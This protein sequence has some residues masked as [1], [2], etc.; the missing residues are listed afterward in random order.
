MSEISYSSSEELRR[1]ASQRGL[2]L[3][4][5]EAISNPEVPLQNEQNADIPSEIPAEFKGE[6]LAEMDKRYGHLGYVMPFEDYQIYKEFLNKKKVSMWN[7]IGE[8]V[9]AT[10]TDLT[11]GAWELT[12]DVATLKVPKVVGS[13]IE[14]AAVGTK[15]WLYMYEQAKYD[16]NSWLSKM[17]FDNHATPEDEYLSY[18][19]A[20]KVREMIHKDQNEGIWVPPKV[21]VGGMEIDLTNPAV[22]QAISYVADPSWLF[23]NLGVESA[24]AK[25]MRGAT[26]AVGLGENLTKASAYALKKASQGFGK[27][28]DM[29]ETISAKI[30]KVD[31]GVGEVMSDMT[32]H[33]HHITAQG[34]IQGNEGLVRS[35]ES[36]LGVNKVTIPAWAQVTMVWGGAKLTEGIGRLGET[37]FKLAS[38]ESKIAGMALSERVALE[39]TNKSIQKVATFWSQNATPFVEWAT[40]TTKVGL[41][42]SMYGGAFGFA[43]GGEEGLYHGLGTGFV[44]GSAFNQ[45]GVL[46]NTVSGGDA[47]RDTVK[48]FLWATSHYDFHNQEGVMRY[49]ENAYAEGGTKAQLRVMSQ[50]AAAER[51]LP[52]DPIRILTEKKIKEMSN[53]I[54][55]EAYERQNLAN[56]EFGGITFVKDKDGKSVILIN[57]D[58]AARSAVSEETFHGLL[59]TKRYGKE[60]SKHAID[61]LVGTEDKLGALYRMPKDKAVALLEQFRDQYFNLEKSTTGHIPENMSGMYKKFNDAIER[62]KGGEKP[63]VLNGFFEEFMASYWNRFVEEKPLDYL[64]KGGDLGLIRNAIEGAKDFYRNTMAKDLQEAGVQLVKGETADMFLIDQNTKQRVRIPMLEKLMKHYVKELNSGMYDGWA[65]NNKKYADTNTLLNSDFDHLLRQDVESGTMSPKSLAEVE[66]EMQ[67]RIAALAE[68]LINLPKE[69][70]GLKLDLMNESGESVAQFQPAKPRKK[71]PKQEVLPETTKPSDAIDLQKERAWFD[72]HRRRFSGTDVAPADL[73]ELGPK[74]GGKPRKVEREAGTGRWS[75]EKEGDFWESVWQ[76]NPRVRITG[77]ATPKE[78]SLFEQYLGQHTAARLR[79]LNLVIET[80]RAGRTDQISNIIRSTVITYE[81]STEDGREQGRFV[82]ERRFVPLELN[83]YFKA[84]PKGKPKDG[85]QKYVVGEA[86]LLTTV[87]DWDA[88][89]RR[90]DFIYNKIDDGELHFKGVRNLFATQQN[91]RESVKALLSNYSLGNQ[92]EAGLK[93]FSRGRGGERDAALK[94]DIVNAAIGFHPTKEMMKKR[95]YKNA[96]LDFQMRE[97]MPETFNVVK[98]FRVDRMSGV[99]AENGEGFRYD[100]NEAYKRVQANFSPAITRRDNNGNIIPAGAGHIIKDTVYRNKEG[101]H[102]AVYGLRTPSSEILVRADRSRVFDYVDEGLADSMEASIPSLRGSQYTSKNGWLH[103]TPDIYEAGFFEDKQMRVGYIDSQSHLDISDIPFGTDMRTAVSTVASRIAETTG[104]PIGKVTEDLL[105]MKDDNGRRIFDTFQK[106]TDPI[107]S[108]MPT[109]DEWLMTANSK[110]L[111]RD[112]GI[113]SVGYKNTNPITGH[114]YSS[115]A[116]FEPKRF[117]E[118]RQVKG[119]NDFMFQPSKTIGDKYKEMVKKAGSDDITA[120]LKFKINEAGEVVPRDKFEH[121]I[122]EQSIRDVVNFNEMLVSDALK[123]LKDEKVFTQETY[124]RFKETMTPKVAQVLRERFKSAPKEVIDKIAQFSMDGYATYVS[125]LAVANRQISPFGRETYIPKVSLNADSALIQNASKYGIT[126]KTLAETGIPSLGHWVEMS[127][128]EYMALKNYKN[129]GRTLELVKNDRALEAGAKIAELEKKGTGYGRRLSKAERDAIR[130]PLLDIESMRT[131]AVERILR[132]NNGIAGLVDNMAERQKQLV[133]LVDASILGTGKIGDDNL[134][135]STYAK[136]RMMEAFMK[137]NIGFARQLIKTERGYARQSMQEIVTAYDAIVTSRRDI[138]GEASEAWAMWDRQNREVQNIIS[139][140]AKQRILDFLSAYHIKDVNPEILDKIRAK[141]YDESA[142]GFIELGTPEAIARSVE[143]YAFYEANGKSNLAR[144]RESIKRNYIDSINALEKEGFYGVRWQ[145]KDLS[146]S[147]GNVAINDTVT[148][149][150]VNRAWNFDGTHLTVIEAISDK[151]PSERILTLHDK[152]GK[153]LL[154][155]PFQSRVEKP[156]K[157]NKGTTLVEIPQS[158]IDDKVDLFLQ[159]STQIVRNKIGTGDIP[160]QQL[161]EGPYQEIKGNMKNLLLEIAKTKRG[162][163][164]QS[165]NDRYRLYRNGD[166]F[167]AQEINNEL[168]FDV[169]SRIKQLEEQLASGKANASRRITDAERINITNR[170]NKIEEILSQ[171][172]FGNP[173]REQELRIEMGRLNEQLESGTKK[174]DKLS[175]T[176]ELGIDEKVKLRDEITRL[177]KF[178]TQDLGFSFVID[179]KYNAEVVTFKFGSLTERN[180]ELTKMV[181][182]K[183]RSSNAAFEKFAEK[184]FLEFNQFLNGQRLKEMNRLGVILGEG[185]HKDSV[186]PQI[187]QLMGKL[188]EM[189]KVQ[190]GFYNTEK[191]RINN[192]RRLNGQKPL[193]EKKIVEQIKKDLDALDDASIEA[194]AMHLAAAEQLFQLNV[195]DKMNGMTPERVEELLYRISAKR[196]EVDL[197]QYHMPVPKNKDVVGMIGELQRSLVENGNKFAVLQ[198][199]FNQMHDGLYGKSDEQTAIKEQIG[200]LSRRYLYAKGIKLNAKR[201]FIE[202]ATLHDFDVVSK[203]DYMKLR[204][205]RPQGDGVSYGEPS[206]LVDVDGVLGKGHEEYRTTKDYTD[207]FKARLVELKSYYDIG[208]T[209]GDLSIKNILGIELTPAN[210]DISIHHHLR[211]RLTQKNLGDEGYAWA[212]DPRNRKFIKSLDTDIMEGR[213]D[214][215][216]AVQR[217]KDEQI[218]S[219]IGKDGVDLKDTVQAMSDTIEKIAIVANRLNLAHRGIELVDM[220]S[221][222]QSEFPMFR[223]YRAEIPK[224]IPKLETEL[225]KLRSLKTSLKQRYENILKKA[226]DDKAPPEFKRLVAEY[227]HIDYRE[228]IAKKNTKQDRQ[229][230]REMEKLRKSSIKNLFRQYDDFAKNLG[231]KGIK[232]SRMEIHPSDPRTQYIAYAFPEISSD[233]FQSSWRQWDLNTSSPEGHPNAGIVGGRDSLPEAGALPN[234]NPAIKAWT[235]TVGPEVRRFI[236][237]ES[238]DLK[239]PV[240]LADYIHFAHAKRAYHERNPSMPMSAAD[241]HLLQFFFPR[242]TS[243]GLL[244]DKISRVPEEKMK[245]HEAYTNGILDNLKSSTEKERFIRSFVVDALDLITD[246]GGLREAALKKLKQMSDAEFKQW[247]EQNPDSVDRSLNTIE[248]LEQSMYLLKNGVV[249][250]GNKGDRFNYR[251]SIHTT[252]SKDDIARIYDIAKKKKWSDAEVQKYID[253]GI[254]DVTPKE[255]R[256]I[257]ARRKSPFI[258][259]SDIGHIP[260]DSLVRMQGFMDVWKQEVAKHTEESLYGIERNFGIKQM[261]EN[262]PPQ[263]RFNLDMPTITQMMKDNERSN[264]IAARETKKRYKAQNKE[265]LDEASLEQFQF[266]E[267]DTLVMDEWS[268]VNQILSQALSTEASFIKNK[269]NAQG[270]ISSRPFALDN[271]LSMKDNLRVTDLRRNKDNTMSI[272]W[273]NPNKPN[274]RDTIDGRYFIK[275]ELTK[276]K[277]GS[278][279]ERF[280]IYFKGERFATPT[281]QKVHEIPTTRF[282]STADLTEAQVMIRFFED[283]VIRVK[284]AAAMI[285]GGNNKFSE[286]KVGEQDYTPL[287]PKQGLLINWGNASHFAEEVLKLYKE[288]KGKP[289]FSQLMADKL[290]GIGQYGEMHYLKWDVNGKPRKEQLLITP[291]KEGVMAKYFDRKISPDGHTLWVRKK[292]DKPTPEPNAATDE[293]PAAQGNATI[294]EEARPLS[295]E[296]KTVSDVSN[297]EIIQSAGPTPDRPFEDWVIVRNRLKYTII[298]IDKDGKSI[299]RVFNPASVFMA[300]TYHEYEAVEEM[301]KQ[302]MK[303]YE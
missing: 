134:V 81:K 297:F 37:T 208:L 124:K 128:G 299:F 275:R 4:T 276:D 225:K 83:M 182:H 210:T 23:P 237:Q 167:I 149:K 76:G 33:E 174:S 110:K 175:K 97:A 101:E 139:D 2:R 215:N 148:I 84:K 281:G 230:L 59:L 201:Q 146:K 246:N 263:E 21:N 269:K 1:Y 160:A 162:F 11:T 111:F 194:E 140:D 102:I 16:K 43:F 192:E 129:W 65:L 126:P 188:N 234:A 130:V 214:H 49:L 286:F 288:N 78:I 114:E 244:A 198:D 158:I 292:S 26:A 197:N 222:I 144:I 121:Q 62:F 58:R 153:V 50:I 150:N 27:L 98:S 249:T 138:A 185:T 271:L 20:L 100:H 161:I 223:K 88:Y 51:L 216:E 64:L 298:K 44:I 145:S 53:S 218:I 47:V 238:R 103:F 132:E 48:Q 219:S 166:Y 177:K 253:A 55:W 233:F 157:D 93:L 109:M 200:F 36:G 152:D 13:S 229:R 259:R 82:E 220:N 178:Q 141:L 179:K 232:D 35:A 169:P 99:R 70:R 250:V 57:A 133:F 270:F 151:N 107:S 137:R 96:P 31:K 5:E 268:R 112:Y 191:K 38:E 245:Q 61:A 89:L 291:M 125:S 251:D 6:Y 104:T 115:V 282:A 18:Q 254:S 247:K 77:L 168:G 266:G 7:S 184:A 95:R 186:I 117:I 203:F 187:R 72:K 45:I 202:Q 293:N 71:K 264:I 46:H 24:I 260:V 68:A 131:E 212:N 213:I 189:E 32:G 285:D 302:E 199:K 204:T 12:K 248:V 122:T 227:R 56:P 183:G 75:L 15:N 156:T 206:Y 40:N 239:R 294:S 127:E 217:I 10:T 272:D 228:A 267:N 256:P 240:Y 277:K 163:M 8:A 54:E 243:R 226:G 92:A 22:V 105:R 119:L 278:P 118:N 73:S 94:R 74:K 193:E 19:E 136:N 289:F 87:F 209:Q 211:N 242:E 17:L 147:N 180:T 296:E 205:M 221:D 303:Q 181:L 261:Y 29:G 287:D 14:G 255:L 63:T 60:F 301:L 120:L 42:S 172:K 196:R 171:S 123:Y 113:N 290:E 135:L 116:V 170:V 91:L 9:A 265:I 79:E 108:S 300:E 235:S 241:A 159:E 52:D 224:D 80:S 85:I 67:G 90:E 142:K 190:R 39:S 284:R 25:G 69:D 165:S 274:F 34:K 231:M 257:L 207:E 262:L 273:D 154:R 155:K 30:A 164:G 280:S 106:D 3:P 41:H 283:D 143:L 279:V 176:Q 66:K 28:G 236:S 86:R 195:L 252:L 295:D 258:T 173:Q